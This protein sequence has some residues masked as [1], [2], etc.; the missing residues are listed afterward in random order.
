MEI[1]VTKEQLESL[2]D[3]EFK[4]LPFSESGEQAETVCMTLEL[5]GNFKEQRIKLL[6]ERISRSLEEL[7]TSIT[8][9]NELKGAISVTKGIG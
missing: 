2:A 5:I 1:P 3:I 8:D 4:L 7:V 6:N 9:V